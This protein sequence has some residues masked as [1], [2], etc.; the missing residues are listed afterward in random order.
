VIFAGTAIKLL[1]S[2]PKHPIDDE[3]AHLHFLFLP[4]WSPANYTRPELAAVAG[5]QS[6]VIEVDR[7][8]SQHLVKAFG[9]RATFIT[10]TIRMAA[11]TLL[12]Q[13]LTTAFQIA[14]TV[15]RLCRFEYA[16]L[17]KMS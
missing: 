1:G 13:I 3:P 9:P 4:G 11:G 14:W 16:A 10:R 17:L 12:S 15:I 6:T 8:L 5:C 7:I 2:I